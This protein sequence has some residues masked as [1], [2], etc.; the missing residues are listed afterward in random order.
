MLGIGMSAPLGVLKILAGGCKGMCLG[1]GG[2]EVMAIVK[3]AKT[4]LV[5]VLALLDIT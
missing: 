3:D 2:Q 4:V 1:S 5:P